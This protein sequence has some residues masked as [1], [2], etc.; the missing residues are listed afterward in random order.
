MKVIDQVVAKI[1]LFPALPT[2]VHKLLGIINDP[3]SKSTDIV[4]IIQHDPALSANVLKTANSAYLGFA[5]PVNSIGDASFRIGTKKIYQIAISSL[6]HSSVNKPARGYEM[7][8]EDIWKHSTAVSITADN[9]CHLLDI[10]DNGSIFTAALIH[11]IG[12]IAL[13]KY[14][15]ENSDQ[16]MNFVERENLSFGQAENKSLGIDHAE[17]GAQIAAKWNFPEE[18]VDIIRWHHDPNSAPVISVGIDIVHLADA[19]CLM[20]GIGVGKDGL[21]YYYNIDSIERLKLND[22]IVEIALSRLTEELENIEELYAGQKSE[23]PA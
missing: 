22:D 17:V 23:T 16:I 19:I 8:A 9:L 11:D 21:H 2:M 7:K 4:N 18:I 14:V 1:S 3:E 15:D 5:N 10:H 6:M 13:E 12:K 20:Q